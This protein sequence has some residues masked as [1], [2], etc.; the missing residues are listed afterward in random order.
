MSEPLTVKR[1]IERL[2]KESDPDAIVEAFDPDLHMYL[3]V[4]G[5]I[6]V[7]GRKK[8]VRFQTDDP[9]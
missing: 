1:L 4:T 2:S 6:T 5:W 8:A 3:P 7:T 9:S